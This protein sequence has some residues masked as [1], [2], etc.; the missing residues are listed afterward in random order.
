MSYHEHGND[1][2]LATKDLDVVSTSIPD[3][4][5]EDE[6]EETCAPEST[7]VQDIN[8]GYLSQDGIYC[9]NYIGECTLRLAILY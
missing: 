9:K 4:D 6:E 8:S 7:V 5:A 3:T 1:D 2:V